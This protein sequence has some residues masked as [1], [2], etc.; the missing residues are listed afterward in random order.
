M[1]FL[2]NKLTDEERAEELFS[3]YLD[4]QVTAEERKFLEWYLAD[5]P[6]A[7]T[8]LNMLKAA[9]QMTKTLPPVKAPRSFVL[10]RS[11][12][13]KPALA[14]RLYPMMRLATVAAT[15]LFI[16]AA[17]GDLATMSRFAPAASAPQSV[18]LSAERAGLATATAETEARSAAAPAPTQAPQP[19]EA[20]ASS[21]TL[22][23]AP[24]K[25]AEVLGAAAT[26]S[27]ANGAPSASPD[28]SFATAQATPVPATPAQAVTDQ[29]AAG[30]SQAKA[31]PAVEEAG[32]TAPIDGLRIAE[33]VLA[34]SAL[35]LAATTF[36]LRR[37][38]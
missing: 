12:A 31:A 15:A 21:P 17:A 34:G 1:G 27:G 30:E 3:P 28:K 33:I 20:P 26:A 16:F 36:I 5:H 14:L 19:T 10:P 22:V 18:P 6:E 24:A 38:I 35:L 9:V 2:S 11:M 25:P 7:R 32:G 8:Q 4:N 37:R 23:P 13:R 29:T